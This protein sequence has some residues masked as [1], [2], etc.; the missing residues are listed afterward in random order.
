MARLRLWAHCRP[1]SSALLGTMAVAVI[2]LLAMWTLVPASHALAA[3]QYKSLSDTN[4]YGTAIHVSRTGFAPGVGAVVL[5]SG[6]TYADALSVAPLAAA[7][8]GPVLLTHSAALDE[9]TAAEITRLQPGKIFLV[10]LAAPVAAQVEAAFPGLA[11]APEGIVALMGTD[12]YDTA[13]L[14]AEQVKAKLGAVTGVVLAPGDSF[15]DALSAAPLA[16]A[17]GWPILLTP[18]EGPV[19]AATVQALVALGCHQGAR[20]RYVRRTRRARVDF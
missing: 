3:P 17:Q 4:R 18:A 7:Y 20:G 11:S 19:P 5:V 10:G 1:V 6:E 13:A 14:V 16:A 12:R 2:A 9:G 8:G 15:A